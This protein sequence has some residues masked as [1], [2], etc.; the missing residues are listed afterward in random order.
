MHRP[1]VASQTASEARI[2]GEVGRH[3]KQIEHPLNEN[4]YE[5]IAF[6]IKSPD[7]ARLVGRVSSYNVNTYKGRIYIIDEHRPIPFEL[8]PGARRMDTITLIATSLRNSA[9]NRNSDKADIE[10]EAFTLTSKSRRLKSLLITEVYR[11]D[12]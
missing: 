5:H 1:I 4:T 9:V 6:T 8:L 7:P 10:C 2:S 3:I 12:L 11:H